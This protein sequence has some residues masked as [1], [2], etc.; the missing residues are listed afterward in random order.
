MA[1]L[2]SVAHIRAARI[3]PAFLI[4]PPAGFVPSPQGVGLPFPLPP[5]VSDRAL[6]V[7]GVDGSHSQAKVK[8]TRIA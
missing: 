5:G 8:N 2:S 6:S 4:D 1:F 7:T 3:S